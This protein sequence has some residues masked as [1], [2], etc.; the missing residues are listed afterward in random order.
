MEKKTS[1]DT[2]YDESNSSP[3]SIKHSNVFLFVARLRSVPDRKI[4]YTCR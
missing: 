4:G 1:D 2:I 3:I